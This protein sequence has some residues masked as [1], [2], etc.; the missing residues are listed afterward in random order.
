MSTLCEE[1]LS[2]CK[3]CVLYRNTFDGIRC[4]STKYANEDGTKSSY[5]PKKGWVKGCGCNMSIGC[6]NPS[7]HCVLGK[8]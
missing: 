1:R 7:K 2:I 6:A 8:W 4:D 5:L 3:T